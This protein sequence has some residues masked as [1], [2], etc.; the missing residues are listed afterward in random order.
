MDARYMLFL[1][2]ALTAC[3]EPR[4][5]VPAG[6]ASAPPLS[7][8]VVQAAEQEW[9][10]T[11]E[12]TGTVRSRTSAAL[13]SKL[14]GYVREVHVA[15]GDRVREGQ[16]LVALDTRDLDTAAARA[17]AVREEMRTSIPEAESGVASAKANLELVQATFRRM[18]EL[19][20]KKSI[21]DQEFDEASARVKAAQSTYDMA[22]ARRA[23]LDQRMAQAEQDVR[24]AQVTRSYA[25]LTA[26]FGG[27]VTAK[28][29][30]IGNLATPGAPLLTI[31][32]ESYRLEATVE[33]SKLSDIRIGKAARVRIDGIDHEFDIR[34]AEVE[35]NVDAASRTFI[36]KLD[37][38]SSAAWRPGQFGRVL[39]SLGSRRVLTLQAGAV[40]ER[41]QLQSVFVA[42]AGF[43]RARLITTGARM[44][45]RVEALSGLTAG[46]QIIFPLPAGLGENSRVEVQ[47]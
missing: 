8:K 27:I 12:A 39:F 14:M 23:Q 13:S 30:E 24:A 28:Q 32:R 5:A 45:D 10:A 29:V 7:V 6:K 41:G 43:A 4:D 34:V 20:G 26:P 42:E 11:Y 18:N 36:A 35:P 47:P 19:Y 22:R 46:D 40:M 9:P 15:L 33:E 31:E 25:E 2:I 16:V 21:S 1:A 3:V 38:P 17:A 37:L 44:G